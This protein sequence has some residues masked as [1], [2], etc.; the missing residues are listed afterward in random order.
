M[1]FPKFLTGSPTICVKVG[2][3]LIVEK[4]ES[5]YVLIQVVCMLKHKVK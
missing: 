4:N 1:E 3:T 2:S 5:Y